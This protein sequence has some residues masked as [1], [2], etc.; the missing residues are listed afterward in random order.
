M[1]NKD[2]VTVEWQNYGQA[3]GHDM[4]QFFMSDEFSDVTLRTEDGYELRGHRILLAISST[5][6]REAFQRNNTPNSMGECLFVFKKNFKV[7]FK[8][9]SKHFNMPH[10]M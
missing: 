2:V 9:Q 6:F 8:C 5:Y 3:L 10:F 1:V 7:M 4:W